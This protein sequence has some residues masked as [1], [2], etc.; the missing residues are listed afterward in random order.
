M[1][2][3][4]FKEFITE[5]NNLHG[6]VG[7]DGK[8]LGHV[9]DYV[10]PF[11]SS[12][13]R[14]RT[15]QN[16]KSVGGSFKNVEND[17]EHYKADAPST[18]KLALKF[19]DHPA[20]TEVRI[21][22][23]SG[24]GSD[25]RSLVAHTESHGKIPLSKIEKPAALKKPPKTTSGFDAEAK[26]SRNLGTTAAGSSSTG[27]DFH[28]SG[29]AK[30]ASKPVV[31]GKIKTVVTKSGSKKAVKGLDRPDVRGESKLIKGKFGQSVVSWDRNGGWAFRN[32]SKMNPMLEKATVVGKDGKRRNIIE[33]LNTHHPDGKI[34]SGFR[35]DAHPG[36]TR[37]YL[38]SSEIN[39]L[40]IHHYEKDKKTGK[41]KADRG[42]T[43]TVG[44][45]SLK[46]NTNLSHL[47]DSDVN[48]L[49]GKV[50][51]LRT[52]TGRAE[53]TH[54]PSPTIM[55]EF[56]HRAHSEEGHADLSNPQHAA[57]FKQ[58]VDKHIKEYQKTKPT[59]KEEAPANSMG[60]G[61]Q[62]LS[63]AQGAPI[64]GYDKILPGAKMLRRKALE[65]VI[66]RRGT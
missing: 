58:H 40:H 59:I 38:N 46:G 50:D 33:H 29:N 31:R 64:A 37:H 3:K 66:R 63:S 61:P 27:F 5:K 32:K 18:H 20:G 36:T 24:S 53:V 19:G 1:Q 57:T 30:N 48:R 65:R 10:M 6:S 16:L 52:L 7:A 23:V 9:R 8:T 34:E 25:G 43:Y 21:T 47:S 54:R 42:T 26:L 60:A 56:A 51:I 41:V 22:H 12:A 17:G 45:T 14:K 35:A 39:A 62:G 55:R 15:A 4:E 49:D 2:L 11:L 44:K 28:Y 13:G